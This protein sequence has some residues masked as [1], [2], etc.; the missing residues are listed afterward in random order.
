LNKGV[1]IYSSTEFTTFACLTMLDV[2]LSTAIL[3]HTYW[4]VIA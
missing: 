3:V 1:S 2:P 4:G